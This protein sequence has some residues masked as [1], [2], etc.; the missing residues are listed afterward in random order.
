LRKSEEYNLNLPLEVRFPNYQ[1]HYGAIYH[2]KLLPTKEITQLMRGI[3]F[4]TKACELKEQLTQVSKISSVSNSYESEKQKR[5][6]LKE[7]LKSL[8]EKSQNLSKE[9]A[10][11]TADKSLISEET[12]EL[13][14]KL[15]TKLDNLQNKDNEHQELETK[16]AQRE[17]ELNNLKLAIIANKPRTEKYLERLLKAQQENNTDLVDNCKEVLRSKEIKT[18]E[19]TKL[20]QLQSEITNLELQLNQNLEQNKQK[21]QEITT[22][23]NHITNNYGANINGTVNI[24]GGQTILGGH[25]QGITQTNNNSSLISGGDASDLNN[26]SLE[27]IIEETNNEQEMEAVIEK[28]VI[29]KINQ[30]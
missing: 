20:C 5:T 1:I 4:Q 8:L 21:T 14:K 10:K 3:N 16:K 22:I 18:D 11:I 13:L 17:E 30:K 28:L 24:S 12:S 25:N 7:A 6:A 23:I 15:K 19:I 29:T 2:S 27:Q 9:I 26:N